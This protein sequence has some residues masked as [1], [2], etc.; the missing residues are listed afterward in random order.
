M[1]TAM[2]L[3]WN[4]QDTSSPWIGCAFLCMSKHLHEFVS[5]SLEYCVSKKDCWMEHIRDMTHCKLYA[6]IAGSVVCKSSM[7]S[8][9]SKACR[10]YGKLCRPTDHKQCQMLRSWSLGLETL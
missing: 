6:K 2:Y 1:R 3:V 9:A 10:E 5:E 4:R 8:N 7:H